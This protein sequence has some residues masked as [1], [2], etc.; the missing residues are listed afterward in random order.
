MQESIVW[1][2]V[3]CWSMFDVGSSRLRFLIAFVK[4]YI[5]PIFCDCSTWMVR[6]PRV[7]QP[8]FSDCST[9]M[10]SRILWPV[11]LI[12]VPHPAAPKSV[13]MVRTI[14]WL[15]AEYTAWTYCMSNYL[16]GYILKIFGLHNTPLPSPLL[17]FFPSPFPFLHFPSSSPSLLSHPLPFPLVPHLP[18]EVGPLNPTR[19][20][21]ERL[22]GV[23]LQQ[24]L[25]FDL[26]VTELLKQCSQH[27]YFI[28][29]S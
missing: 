19:G 26:N 29:V 13:C 27:V 23:I 25:S 4:T 3:R 24:G 2:A 14:C 16:S 10:V 17:P 20:S 22:L 7:C 6:W 1:V 11:A 5:N 9:W 18:L 12:S 21:G 28:L 15:Y 8:I